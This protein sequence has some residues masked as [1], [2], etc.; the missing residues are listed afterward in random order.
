MKN[1]FILSAM[2][3][4]ALSC[5]AVLASSC[6][7][8]SGGGE[9]LT[10]VYSAYI[11]NAGER[12][13]GPSGSIYT[14]NMITG[15]VS[16]N[17]YIY[18]NNQEVDA[19]IVDA[20]ISYSQGVAYVLT[21]NPAQILSLAAVEVVSATE[22][23]LPLQKVSNPP[24]TDGLDNPVACEVYSNF[25]IVASNS[26]NGGKVIVYN[27]SSM[28]PAIAETYNVDFPIRSMSIAGQIL[29]LATDGGVVSFTISGG[30]LH[31]NYIAVNDEVSGTPYDI[32]ALNE[33]EFIVIC[34]GNGL[35]TMKTKT[36]TTMKSISLPTG[37]TPHVATDYYMS[38]R[39]S[40]A[41]DA[42]IVSFSTN[43][44]SEGGTVYQC[45]PRNVNTSNVVF[46]GGYITGLSCN[47]D[48]ADTYIMEEDGSASSLQMSKVNVYSN[49]S[50][51]NSFRAG[52]NAIKVLFIN[53][54]VQK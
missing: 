48:T 25:L 42:T 24:V 32:A 29:G 23:I 11:F 52:I 8:T 49:G 19:H 21:S 17:A 34:K 4:A 15:E 22:P 18:A 45:Y 30:S 27:V 3:V 28:K 37:D 50:L 20:A 41:T 46:S 40:T 5:A 26:E 9:N 2:A 43:I 31:R 38:N 13:N 53:Y 7:K 14:L 36:G 6:N 33:E 12:E 39:S 47:P 16:P 54:L 1:K 51:K 44:D 10:G 35:Y